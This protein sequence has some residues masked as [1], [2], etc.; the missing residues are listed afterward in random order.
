[1]RRE[2]RR[3]YGGRVPGGTPAA[4]TRPRL[5]TTEQTLAIDLLRFRS[6]VLRA[7]DFGAKRKPMLKS[8]AFGS[9]PMHSS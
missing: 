4:A 9:A 8:A 1:M 5:L 2:I 6:A 3:V 7:A